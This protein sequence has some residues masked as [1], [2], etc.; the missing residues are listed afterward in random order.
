LIERAGWKLLREPTT[1]MGA[2]SYA[3]GRNVHAANDP[4]THTYGVICESPTAT[5]TP[6]QP[7]SYREVWRLT[8]LD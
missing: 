6:A 4:S 8:P 5:V 2:N 1:F 3:L 7:L